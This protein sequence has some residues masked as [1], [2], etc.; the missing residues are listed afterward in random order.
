MFAYCGNNSVNGTDPSGKQMI[1]TYLIRETD[2][3]LRRKIS[4]SPEELF[5]PFIGYKEYEKKSGE[6]K[7]DGCRY[8]VHVRAVDSVPDGANLEKKSYTYDRNP[9]E[10]FNVDD[11]CRDEITYNGKQY[12]MFPVSHADIYYQYNNV[13]F[14][15]TVTVVSFDSNDTWAK[16][17][18]ETLGNI[19]DFQGFGGYFDPICVFPIWR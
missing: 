1:R 12:K 14:R 18:G 4:L 15:I 13:T 11:I 2:G 10:F 9:A 6:L 5:N 8:F 3:S 16:A 7:E 19:A 17:F